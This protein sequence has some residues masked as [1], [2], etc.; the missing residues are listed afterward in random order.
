MVLDDLGGDLM[1]LLL[2]D[3]DAAHIVV[4]D[5]IDVA[6]DILIAPAAAAVENCVD[7]KVADDD[8]VVEVGFGDFVVQEDL[9]NLSNCTLTDLIDANYL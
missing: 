7:C 6:V 3:C 4:A 9:E 1:I 2:V 5:I 8:I